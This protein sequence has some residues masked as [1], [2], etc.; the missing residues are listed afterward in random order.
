MTLVATTIVALAL[1]VSGVSIVGL[2]RRT[3][4]DNVRTDAFVRA[5]AVVDELDRGGSPDLEAGDDSF[6]QVVDADGSVV[7]ASVNLDENAPVAEL[8]AGESTALSEVP[9]EDDRFMVVALET[10]DGSIVLSGQALDGVDESIAALAALLLV[11]LPLLVAAIGWLIWLMVGRAL[12]PMEAIRSEV[13][14]ISTDRLQRRVPVPPTDDEVARLA[15]TMNGMLERLEEGHERERRFVS[16]ASHELRSPVASIRQHAEVALSHPETSSVHDLAENVL[17]ED[18]RL[19]RIVEDLLMLARMDED[20]FTRERS[21]VDLDDLVLAEVGRLEATGVAIDA[22]RVSAGRVSGDPRQLERLVVNLLD[23]AVRHAG[24]R[25]R[26]SLGESDGVVLFAVE[27][28]GPGVPAAERDRVFERFVRLEGSRDRDSGGAGLGL[29]IVAEV[30]S[31]HGGGAGVE[32]SGLGGARF[33][34]RLPRSA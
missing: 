7:L 6:V 3:L 30:A 28:D 10:S 18:L 14:S 4:T 1:L 26:V 23:N 21:Q 20:G 13:D 32:G 34:V 15:M 8:Q 29:A 27:D 9:F 33:E 12:R 24:D 16:D 5:E 11:G 22:S 2:L 17:A 31:A 25:V 19:Q